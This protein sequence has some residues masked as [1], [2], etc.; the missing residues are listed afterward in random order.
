MINIFSEI[1]TDG[2]FKDFIEDLVD[3]RYG[4]INVR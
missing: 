2:E 1:M 4:D 3:G